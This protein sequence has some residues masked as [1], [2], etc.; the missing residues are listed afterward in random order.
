MRKK[1]SKLSLNRE[2]V[3]Q[4]TPSRLEPLVAGA[5]AQIGCANTLEQTCKTCQTCNFFT[6]AGTICTDCCTTTTR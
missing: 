3:K 1:R 5:T 2:T 4:L 6:C